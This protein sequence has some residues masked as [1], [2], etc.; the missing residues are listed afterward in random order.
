MK[1]AMSILGV[2][3]LGKIK[4]KGNDKHNEEELRDNTLTTAIP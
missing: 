2:R 4:Y 1:C 3:T